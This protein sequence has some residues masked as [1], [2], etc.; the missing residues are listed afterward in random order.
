MDSNTSF[1]TMGSPYAYVVAEKMTSKLR[2]KKILFIALYVLW[3]GGVLVGGTALQVVAP[4]LAFIPIS[5]W[6]L[7]WLTWRFTQVSYEY[8][9]ESGTL[10]VNRM[11][12]ER[13]RRK[14]AE[15]KIRD[16]EKIYSKINDN[17]GKLDTFGCDNTIFAASSED[18]ERLIAILWTNENKKTVLYMEADEKAL[19]ILRYYNSSAF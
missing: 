12:G 15:L 7:I 5:L 13:S 19:K 11:L 8:A 1:G 18:A 10:K 3:G 9:F 16:I 4:L 6:I 14:L 17:H 2:M